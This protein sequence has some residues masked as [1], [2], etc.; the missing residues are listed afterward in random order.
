MIHALL[1]DSLRT[2]VS[3]VVPTIELMA[4]LIIAAGT[5]EGFV[6]GSRVMWTWPE[7]PH[8]IRAVWL[9]Y[10]RWLVAGLTFQLAADIIA[11]SVAPSWEEI[12]KL[13]AIAAIRTFLNYF[14]ERDQE[15]M[16][17]LRDRNAEGGRGSATRTD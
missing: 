1:H 3:I 8:E 14:L 15:E 5:I 12:G 2:A 7:R 16:R 13:A 6:R 10:S 9:R 11:T 4:L 17:R